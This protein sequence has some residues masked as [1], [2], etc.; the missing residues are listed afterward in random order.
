M[1]FFVRWLLLLVVALDLAGSPFHPHAHDVDVDRTGAAVHALAAGG[2]AN[3]DTEKSHAHAGHSVVAGRLVRQWDS[4]GPSDLAIVAGLGFLLDEIPLATRTAR[5]ADPEP[6]ARQ[7]ALRWWPDGRA[8][9]VS[10]T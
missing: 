5:A 4:K 1:R 10:R 8:P 2:A 6:A 9:P 3:L 7:A